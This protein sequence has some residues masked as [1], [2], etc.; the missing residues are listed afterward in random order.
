[1]ERCTEVVHR[2]GLALRL[3]DTVSGQGISA[4]SVQV[5]A[6]GKPLRCM[7]K[8]GGLL[9]FQ[10]VGETPFQLELRSREYEPVS[11]SV[12]PQALDRAQPLLE[13]HLIPNAQHISAVPLLS[14]EGT[15]PGIGDI[16]AVRSGDSPCL[17]REMDARRRTFKIF[18]PHHLELSRIHYALVDPDKELFVPFRILQRKDPQTL[19]VDQTPDMAF[20]NYFPISPIVFGWVSPQGQYAL[21]V[22]DDARSARWIIRY[23]VDGE[24]RFYTAD[25][26]QEGQVVLC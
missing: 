12:D 8:A 14:L 6:D 23:T 17:I 7:E 26:H 13:L 21:R 20:Q 16:C 22:R 18:N 11:L 3:L 24:V 19:Q 2:L 9:I 5:M 1:M 15:L 25:L 4:R 10:E